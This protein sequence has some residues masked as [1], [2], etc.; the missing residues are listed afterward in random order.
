MRLLA[1]LVL[2]G[3]VLKIDLLIL[4]LL[5]LGLDVVTVYAQVALRAGEGRA[6]VSSRSARR[7]AVNE[8]LRKLE[9]K[10]THDLAVEVG[11]VG[12]GRLIGDGVRVLGDRA[13]ER[14]DALAAVALGALD[15]VDGVRHLV[16]VVVLREEARRRRRRAGST[17]VTPSREVSWSE[18]RRSE[19]EKR[20]RTSLSSLLLNCSASLTRLLT[21]LSTLSCSLR[22][23]LTKPAS[24]STLAVNGRLTS[25]SCATSF[26]TRT[27]SS[28]AVSYDVY[29]CWYSANLTTTS[30]TARS[31][32]RRSR[33]S[34]ARTSFSAS[35]CLVCLRARTSLRRATSC[36][37]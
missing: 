3:S 20:R 37:R 36:E 24:A 28:R 13:V 1:A 14:V 31:C 11:R 22:H 5:D 18:G 9:E 30:T 25:S 2:I 21:F 23:A 27:L 7:D 12:L 26:L 15:V 6:L 8:Y 35:A 29:T 32:S 10:E 17:S 4:V 19:S 16:A 33:C 34:N